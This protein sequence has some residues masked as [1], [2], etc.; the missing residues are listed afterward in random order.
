MS[1]IELIKM[2][3]IIKLRDKRGLSQ[4]ELAFLLGQRDLYVRDFERPDH[5]LI[6]GLSENNTIR[7]I[8]KCELADFVPLSNDSNNHKIQIRF[9]IDEQGKRVYI[10]E[11]K[12]G[13]G[14]WK[15][16][17]RFGDEEKDILLESS[18]LITDTQVQSWLDEKYNHGYFNVAK[19]ALE[20]FLDCE[21]HFG[22]PVRPLFIAN[23]I[24]YY[25]KKK[26]APRLVKNRDKM[27]DYDVFV[28]E[29]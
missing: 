3:N 13:N 22:E 10:A 20:I 4:F 15:E 23:A 8:F 14:K 7:I 17:L 24:Q 25:T 29:M 2:L 9:H 19:S 21:A 16:F 12:I 28:G 6:L 18:S 11:Q 26:K 5:T 27:N 1:D